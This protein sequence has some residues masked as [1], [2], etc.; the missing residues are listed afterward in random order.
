MKVARIKPMSR[1]KPRQGADWKRGTP[2]VTWRRALMHSAEV[3][4][5][6][7]H[8]CRAVEAE[9]ADHPPL[10][11]GRRGTLAPSLSRT[12]GDA[13]GTLRSGPGSPPVRPNRLSI[14]GGRPEPRR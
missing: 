4:P 2:D 7:P 11:A 3:G 12:R 8:P 9:F 1:R 10:T 13:T 14:P 6:R 5:H